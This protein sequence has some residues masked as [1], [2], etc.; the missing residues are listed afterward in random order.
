M[1]PQFHQYRHK[2][3]PS[4]QV[5][6]HADRGCTNPLW[7]LVFILFWGL[8]GYVA[9]V[10]I[11]MGNLNR[12]IYG[13][14]YLGNICSQTVDPCNGVSGCT[15]APG[16]QNRTNLW[17]PITFD[18]NRRTFLITEARQLGICVAECPQKGSLVSTYGYLTNTTPPPSTYLS[19]FS[20]TAMYHRCVPSFLSFE[21]PIGPGYND[22]RAK[23]NSTS[24]QY[25]QL[26]AIT[27]AIN[28]A[29][30]DV[31]ER[32]WV[33]LCG[34]AIAIV[35][36]FVWLF[37]IRRLVKPVVVLTMILVF[38]LIGG[39][40][41][42][43]YWRSLY[44]TD[45]GDD[46]SSKYYLY[47]AIACWVVDFL[48]LCVA[49]FLAKDIMVACDI[50]EEASKVPFSIPTM[51]LVPP[52]LLIFLLPFLFFALFIAANIQTS[53]QVI[54]QTL[55]VPQTSYFAGNSTDL[56]QV[57]TFEIQNWKDYA[58]VFNVFMFLW[59]MGF[60]HAI[61]FMICAF[62]AIF[63]YWSVP[64]D[65]KKPES[66]VCGAAG[67]CLKNH[68]GTLALGSFIIAVIQIIR[69][70]IG[71]MEFRLRKLSESAECVKFLITCAQ[72][73]LAYFERVVK[74]INKNAYI[75]TCLTGES[76]L[77]AA[78]HALHLLMS[79]ALSVGAVTIIGE[80]VMIFGKLMITAATCAA[81]YGILLSLRSDQSG[82]NIPVSGWIIVIAIAVITYF[83]SSVF[84]SVFGVCID[85]VLL[86]YCYDLEENNGAEKVYYF[87]TDLAKH[88]D[89]AKARKE[90]KDRNKE[91]HSEAMEPLAVN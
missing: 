26:D 24:S 79:N 23:L 34:V 66:G 91:F 78:R 63:W 58:H 89:R 53:A 32:W 15:A 9:Y 41:G 71:L 7:A 90:S 65:D 10:A 37:I 76:F 17:Y 70:I 16:W 45:N 21:C 83:I 42:L 81:T 35:I 12:L 54:T 4:T 33:I 2:K 68:L 85:A 72:C 87:P 20:S 56:M 57:R 75:V 8:M 77:P 14:D 27:T 88:V 69:F 44:H 84:L 3:L 18:T 49:I 52:V 61:G 29:F 59:T 43:L 39:L 36:C 60:I 50:I 62:C 5:G 1:A 48:Y 64:G 25:A 30:E 47:G 55:P 19:L 46:E 82:Y 86:S 13:V 31:K 51:M 6:L 40:G 28:G 22:C 74:F 80:Y 67:L 11:S 38:L 73:C